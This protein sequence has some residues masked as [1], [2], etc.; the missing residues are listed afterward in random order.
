MN[1]D[2]RFYIVKDKENVINK[3]KLGE[4][5]IRGSIK[6]ASSIYSPS[7]TIKNN[8]DIL[9]KNYNYVQIPKFNRF[10]FIDNIIID[11]V[12]STVSL[13]CDVLESFKEDILN[14]TQII[15]RQENAFNLDLVDNELTVTNVTKKQIIKM[16]KTPFNTDDLTTNDYIYTLTTGSI[17][18]AYQ[19]ETGES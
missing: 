9:T 10:Y 14:S 1:I 3:E 2:L 17:Q 6:E 16:P 15:G 5:V 12:Y 7:I 13:S 11:D 19:N 4:I 18:A 8:I